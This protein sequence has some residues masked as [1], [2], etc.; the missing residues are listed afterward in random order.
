MLYDLLGMSEPKQ[1]CRRRHLPYSVVGAIMDPYRSSR[2]SLRSRRKL[3]SSTVTDVWSLC[4]LLPVWP[5]ISTLVRRA[6]HRGGIGRDNSLTMPGHGIVNGQT[7]NAALSG[8]ADMRPMWDCPCHHLPCQRVL[9]RGKGRP[10][11]LEGL[12]L[13]LFFLFSPICNPCSPLAYKRESKT[14][15]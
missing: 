9:H 8:S 1:C 14:P 5:L 12:P 13:P 2:Q 3:A 10:G 11:V 7:P 15:H 6:A 4:C